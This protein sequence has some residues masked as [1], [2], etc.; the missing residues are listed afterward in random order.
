MYVLCG[1]CVWCVW[2]VCGVYGVCVCVVCMY[3]HVCTG[4]EKAWKDSHRN[5]KSHQV[6]FW[7]L[8]VF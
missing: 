8:E 4:R 7:G 5:I 1:V 2:Y 6:G 3:V